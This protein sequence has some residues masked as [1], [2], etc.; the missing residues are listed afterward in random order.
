MGSKWVMMMVDDYLHTS[1]QRGAVKGDQM[2]QQ[3]GVDWVSLGIV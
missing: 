2:V 3:T 1:S